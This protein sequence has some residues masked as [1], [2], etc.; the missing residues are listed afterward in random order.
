[1]DMSNEEITEGAR[2]DCTDE[3]FSKMKNAIKESYRQGAK[4]LQVMLAVKYAWLCYTQ[5]N[6]GKV[7]LF[8]EKEK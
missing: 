8:V 7:P 6:G 2:L 3:V 5:E 1:M 4:P